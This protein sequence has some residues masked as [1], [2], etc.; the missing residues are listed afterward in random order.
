MRTLLSSRQWVFQNVQGD[1]FH[2][3]DRK[4]S[5][6]EIVAA[7]LS[8]QD[9]PQLEDT[10]MEQL[11]DT[12]GRLLQNLAAIEP[13]TMAEL[14]LKAERA[15]AGLLRSIEDGDR[16]EEIE[17]GEAI[18]GDLRYAIRSPRRLK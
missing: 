4:A 10:E 7:I 3:S 14:L 11:N 6:T 16:H 2:V 9:P 8:I 18:L 5:I 15:V 1:V 13:A 17:L 12:E